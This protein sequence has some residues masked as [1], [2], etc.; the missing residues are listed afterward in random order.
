[1]KPPS[2][3]RLRE[4]WVIM[5]LLGVI[6]INYPFV[7]IFNKDIL[8]FNYPLLFLY[9]LI[10]WPASIVVVYFFSRYAMDEPQEEHEPDEQEKDGPR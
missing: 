6:M 7:H 10:G 1:M 9:F 5:F 2:P 8:I 3:I 4:V